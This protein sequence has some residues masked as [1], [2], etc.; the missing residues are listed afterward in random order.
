MKLL[1]SVGRK[2]EEDV[3]H[4]QNGMK[5]KKISSQ[6]KTAEDRMGGAAGEVCELRT[7]RTCD[8]GQSGMTLENTEV[9]QMEM[10]N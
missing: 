5:N 6:K 3:R 4:K 9:P 2:N 7:S 1:S 8:P 10:T